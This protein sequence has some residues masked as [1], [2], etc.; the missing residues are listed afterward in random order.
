MGLNEVSY[1]RLA[2]ND[3]N[4]FREVDVRALVLGAVGINKV[5]D[6]SLNRLVSWCQQVDRLQIGQSLSAFTDVLHH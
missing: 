1:M 3:C 6:E 2:N 5:V 4:T